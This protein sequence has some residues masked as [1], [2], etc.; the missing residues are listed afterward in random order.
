M[1]ALAR[2]VA[3]PVC[4]IRSNPDSVFK[5]KSDPDL[6]FKMRSD[7]VLTPKFKIPLKSLFNKYSPKY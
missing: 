6:V 7:P 5:I 2:R 3:E 1:Q 4:K